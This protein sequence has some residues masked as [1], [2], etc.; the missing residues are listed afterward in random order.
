MK[1]LAF[2]IA[3][4]IFG[5]G[6][7]LVFNACSNNRDPSVSY[8]NDVEMFC[9]DHNIS[10]LEFFGIQYY[11]TDS[12]NV[13][14]LDHR[15]PDKSLYVKSTIKASVDQNGTLIVRV[16]DSDAIS[17]SDISGNY[18]VLITSTTTISK[19]EIKQED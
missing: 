10:N 5:I 18:A 19:I 8:I 4:I 1:K 7:F 15:N 11:Q 3:F 13:L 2:L 14:V 12:N 16:I 6:T 17:E 9:Q